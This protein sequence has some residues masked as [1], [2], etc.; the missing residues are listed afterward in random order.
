M[1]NVAP[2]GHDDDHDEVA[3]Q[4]GPIDWQVEDKEE[5]GRGGDEERAGPALPDVDFGHGAQEGAI[6]IV[7]WELD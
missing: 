1:A 6:F 5:S 7:L 2:E 3:Q 4:E